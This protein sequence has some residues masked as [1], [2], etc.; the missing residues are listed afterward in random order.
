MLPPRARCCCTASRRR[1]K[2]KNWMR[3]SI[4]SCTSRPSTGG[5]TSRTS[6]TTR[7]KRSRST[8]REPACPD[9][10]ALKASSTPS[11]PTSST[12]V[13]PTTCASASP[14]GYW[15]RYSLRKCM[16][17]MPSARTCAARCS[18]SCRRSQ[19]KVGC[20][21]SRR[22]NSA[23]GISSS[24]ASSGIWGCWRSMF[25]GMAHTLCAT[26]LVARIRPLRSST[27]PRLGGS[28]SVRS[29]RISPWRWKN[30]LPNTCT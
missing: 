10:W 9:N 18:S 20:R 3:L 16:P 17:S 30:S 19:T 4:E 22:C 1:W 13:K 23:G 8:R 26:T 24:R 14:S 2:A 21:S 6:S 15:R 29:K 27:R 28:S 7:P 5:M 11:W 25:S 12:L